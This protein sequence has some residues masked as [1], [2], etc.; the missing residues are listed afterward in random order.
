MEDY[1]HPEA[2]WEEFLERIA[3]ENA[4]CGTVW[5]PIHGTLRPWIDLEELGKLNNVEDS[6]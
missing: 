3:E 2:E 4:R 5:S 1:P 6:V